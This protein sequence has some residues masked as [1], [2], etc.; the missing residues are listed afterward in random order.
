VLLARRADGGPL[1]GAWDLPAFELCDGEDAG[2]VLR[3]RLARDYDLAVETRECAGP[4]EHAIMNRRLRLEIVDCRLRRGRLA[5][6][7]DLRVV[8]VEALEAAPV[9]SATRKAAA[10]MGAGRD[11]RSAHGVGPRGRGRPRPRSPR[12]R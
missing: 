10:A 7:E 12:S 8:E 4:L 11:S 6:R 5:R 3:E 9:S 2:T 1:R